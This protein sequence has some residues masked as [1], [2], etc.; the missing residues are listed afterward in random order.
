MV[1]ARDLKSLGSNF[2][3]RFKSGRPH[4]EIKLSAA[5]GA[6]ELRLASGPSVKR[7][8]LRRQDR[9]RPAPTHQIDRSMNRRSSALG[10][11][12][13]LRRVLAESPNIVVNEM[14]EIGET[15][16]GGNL[17]KRDGGIWT[18]QQLVRMA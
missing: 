2:P 17:G 15:A 1:D 9:N 18:A 10:A 13:R 4:Q 6:D 12:G 16:G 11:A 14:A 7:R 8:L 5:R 3:C